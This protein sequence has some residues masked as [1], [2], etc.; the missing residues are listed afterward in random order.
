MTTSDELT[1]SMNQ[2][3]ARTVRL[4]R[5]RG[6][7]MAMSCFWRCVWAKMPSSTAVSTKRRMMEADDHG[8]LVPPHCRASSSV[9][10]DVMSRGRADGV[11][12]DSHQ[13]HPLQQR[14]VLGECGGHGSHAGILLGR[15]RREAEDKDDD[16]DND[17]AN[18]AG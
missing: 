10:M 2:K 14:R 13:A 7:T 4:R 17:G 16:G 6:D 18:G 3:P 9:M 11:Q 15:G 5:M 1:Q 12:L 8:Y